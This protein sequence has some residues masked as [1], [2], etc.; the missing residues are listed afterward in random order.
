MSRPTPACACSHAM[1]GRRLVK[2]RGRPQSPTRRT[3]R[4]LGPRGNLEIRSRG[5]LSR[6]AAAA[7]E[8][9]LLLWKGGCC[10]GRGAAAVEGDLSRAAAAALASVPPPRLAS[11]SLY[12][13][14]GLASM[15]CPRPRL[16][17]WAP[18]GPMASALPSCVDGLDGPSFA[19]LCSLLASPSCL[20]VLP[21][22]CPRPAR[23][24]LAQLSASCRIALCRAYPS[25]PLAFAAAPRPPVLPSSAARTTPKAQRTAHART[26]APPCLCL[27]RLHP[28]CGPAFSRHVACGT[29]EQTVETAAISN[30]RRETSD[31]VLRHSLQPAHSVLSGS[32]CNWSR[33]CPLDPPHLQRRT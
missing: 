20:A 17:R 18:M 33:A 24:A 16:P 15:P 29:S 13:A 6:A 1:R 14:G 26:P 32:A 2:R 22:P 4:L 28:L 11:R 9:G 23:A 10:C 25:H 27:P 5:D 8:G 19:L 31:G 3:P 30:G 12:H 7:V 21:C